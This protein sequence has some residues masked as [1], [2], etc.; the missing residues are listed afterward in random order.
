MS[1]AQ[2]RVLAHQAATVLGI[3]GTVFTVARADGVPAL[4]QAHVSFDYAGFRYAYGGSYASRL[5]LVEL[6]PCALTTPRVPA[7]REQTS[8]VS[9]D[10]VKTAR[11]GADVTVPGT[12]AA[13]ASASS[14]VPVVSLTAAVPESA[15]VLAVTASAQGSGGDYAAEPLSEMDQWI[16]GDSSGAYQYT[17]KITAP[18]VPGGLEPDASLRYDSQL[19]DGITAATNPQASEAGDGWKSPVPGYIEIDYQTCAANFS[20]PD[21]LDLCNKVQSESVT[22]DGSTTPIVLAGSTGVYKEENDDGSAV[23]QL[24]GGGWEITSSDG[25]K[26]Y[27]GLNKLPGWASG[28][29]QT[30]STWTVPLWSG[31]TE[32]TAAA[33]WRYML[34]YV[35]DSKGNAIA[36]FYN[37][38]NNYYATHGGSTANGQYTAGGVLATTEYGLRDNGNVYSQTPAAEINYT[39]S[40]TR[41]DAPADLACASGAACAVHAPTF[42]TSD[43][44]G[45]IL[46]KSLVNGSLKPVDSYQLTDSYPPTGDSTT[47]PSLW[48]TSIQQTGEDGTTPVTLPATQFAG[49]AMANLDQ[50]STD[51]SA[52]YSLLTRDRL[53]AITGDQGGVT[54]IAYT[55]ADSACSSGKFPSLWANAGRCY[56]GYWYTNPLADTEALDWYNLYAAA[57]VTE[58]DTTGGGKPVVT[59]YS[60]GTPGWHYDNDEISR[61]AYP[62]WDE[63]RGFKTVTTEEGTSPDPVTETVST[64]YQGLSNDTGAYAVTSGEE[65]NGTVTL[66]T[67]HGISVTDD[68]QNAGELLETQVFTARAAA[69]SLTPST[70]CQHGRRRPPRRP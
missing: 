49:T 54:K 61:S 10:D 3:T 13:S 6:P 67:S 63:W 4:G 40:T 21:I 8:L 35:V 48:L 56:P 45:Q 68:D 66:T 24:S 11:A 37:T 30:N 25:T 65:G 38:Q 44:L 46:T 70:T 41:Q 2:V 9:G 64:Y 28:D 50:T 55:G 20:E 29:T 7:C 39:Y 23:Q 31:N 14:G 51:K 27:Y 16:S 69:R 17:Y 60:Y 26:A 58:T 5:R 22:T 42:W 1:K 47:A 33:P 34:D 18:P 52:G 32:Q 53:T 19:A 62:T 15:V 57:T 12:S 36:Y 59:A 43:V